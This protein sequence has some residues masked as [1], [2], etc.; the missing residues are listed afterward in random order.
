[1]PCV[2]PAHEAT[3]GNCAWFI[4]IRRCWEMA[5]PTFLLTDILIRGWQTNSQVIGSG[6]LSRHEKK[7]G[8]PDRRLQILR[9]KI[10]SLQVQESTSVKYVHWG[11]QFYITR[12]VVPN[13]Y[14]RVKKA[15]LARSSFKVQYVQFICIVSRAASNRAPLDE[16][17][18]YYFLHLKAEILQ[19]NHTCEE[20]VGILTVL[21]SFFSM[22]SRNH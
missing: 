7:I 4:L 20:L 6:V 11:A 18:L 13:G 19:T 12:Q 17:F 21:P 10:D 5:L 9:I 3:S 22:V 16:S 8:T 1:M 2:I 15:S 14:C